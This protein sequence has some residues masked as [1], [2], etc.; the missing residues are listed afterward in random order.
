MNLEE[1]DKVEPFDY[2]ALKIAKSFD[3]SFEFL[4]K[5]HDDKIA[6]DISNGLVNPKTMLLYAPQ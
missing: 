1:I 6:Q 3:P 4:G 5:V 2:M